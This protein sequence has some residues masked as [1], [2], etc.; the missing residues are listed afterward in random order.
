M[1]N[2]YMYLVRMILCLVLVISLFGCGDTAEPAETTAPAQTTQSQAA[3]EAPTTVPVE[4]EPVYEL[5]TVYLCVE[6]YL[7]NYEG[8]NF[9]KGYT[10]DEYGRVTEYFLIQDDGTRGWVTEYSYDE[11][12]NNIETRTGDSVTVMTYDEA[13]H[14][15]SEI[16]YYK[17][18]KNNETHYEYDA[19][20]Y[21]IAETRIERYS[22]ETTY[23][24]TITYNDDHTEARIDQFKNGEPNG[25]TVETNNAA[26][27][28]LS[29]TV[30]D[31]NGNWKRTQTWTYDEAGR[32]LQEGNY[33]S[34]ETQADYMT[35]YTY[36]DNGLLLS[37]NV[38][39][40]NGYLLEF[41]Y[42]PFE[43]LVRVN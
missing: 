32:L 8:G 17:E 28:V 19:Q 38:D 40:Y 6:E 30:H 39:Y 21:V 2:R 27:Q 9:R 4:T 5:Q 23:T 16:S 25:K 43:I 42:E 22:E 33:S 41:T 3:T 37:K 11:N 1:K 10:Y 14:L 15:L 24:F 26:G 12:G 29:S 7:Q 13:G 31:A 20:G 18:E 35:I 34:S 36:D